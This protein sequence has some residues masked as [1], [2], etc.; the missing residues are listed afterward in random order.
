M[1]NTLNSVRDLLAQ[2][3]PVYPLH[4][5]DDMTIRDSDNCLYIDLSPLITSDVITKSELS[6]WRTF[7]E[8]I[9]DKFNPIN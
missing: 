8:E 1:E 6:F 7:L 9:C 5:A 2:F 3:P 4:V